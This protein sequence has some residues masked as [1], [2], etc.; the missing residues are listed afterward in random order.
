MSVPTPPRV[1]AML[2]RLVT[3]HDDRESLLA[4]L[5]MGFVER[6]SD[7]ARARRWYW[8]Q[9]VGSIPALL[10]RRVELAL[11][12]GGRATVNRRGA[13]LA[14]SAGDVRHAW[15]LIRRTPIVSVSVVT[16]IALGIASVTAIVSVMEGVF[17]RSLPFPDAQQLVQVGTEIDG[18]GRAPEVNFLDARDFRQRSTTLS[19]I[20]CYA[21]NPTA[22]RLSPGQLS[23]SA[24]ILAAGIDL[25]RVLGLRPEIGRWFDA[26]EQ[27]FGGQGVVLVSH[28]FWRQHL[29]A[30]ADVVGR[31]I[32][33]GGADHTIVGVLPDAA[34]R[35][36][37]GGADLWTPLTFPSE[38][39][40]NQRGS[41]ALGAV[42]RLRPG[43][44]ESAARAD[45]SAISRQLAV[46]HADTNSKRR[47][48]IENL[49]D[50][51]VG[52]IRP[53][54][55]ALAGAI[56]FLLA[57]ACLNIAN[58]LLAH[59]HAR[60]RELG[61]R[62][63]IG[64]SRGRLLRQ[65]SCEHLTLFT[66]AGAVG[67]AGAGP[68][69]RAIVRW[70]PG[71]LPLAADIRI[72]VRV[73]AV[74]ALVTFGAML[75]ALAPQAIRL[76]RSTI[77]AD[78]TGGSRIGLSHG[79]RRVTSAFIVVQV[80]MSTVLLAGGVL[81]LRTFTNL[82][83]VSP[84]FS[85][86]GVV[87]IRVSLPADVQRSGEAMVAFQDRVRDVA[88][89]LPGVERAAHAMFVP[90]TSGSWG[91]AY[92]VPGDTRQGP[93]GPLAHFYMVSPEYLS[94]LQ[95]P[96]VRGRGLAS[97]DSAGGARVLVVSE[98][99]ARQAF[100]RVDVVGEH[101]DWN[102][103]RW[104]L[105]GVARDVRHAS[106][107]QAPDADAYVPRAQV[108]RSPT[109]LVLRTK[110]PGPIVAG[111]IYERLKA[112]APQ[113]ALT[114]AAT[115]SGLLAA[116]LAPER[117]RALLT[118]VIAALSLVLAV[119]GL[120]GVVAYAVSRRSREI[121]VRIALG[122]RRSTVLGQIFRESGRVVA[123]GL[124]PGVGGAV[125]LARWLSSQ[126]V[127]QASIGGAIGATVAIFAAAAFIATFT[128][129]RRASRVDP[130]SVLR[131]E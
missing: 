70:Y 68:L 35:F 101:I 27:A 33:I 73:L 60:T 122:A 129:A 96:L 109:W 13:W 67:V 54:M 53:M 95:V 14:E 71:D 113:L 38:S 6:A 37:T 105:V 28:R 20:A 16:A 57:V 11:R 104:T 88:A 97:S 52:P 78:L 127:V 75:L 12:G 84:G 64:A 112:E 80:A 48:T 46:E 43:V 55:L 102:D 76:R 40:L 77:V 100:G 41:I 34:S 23:M 50:A 111:Q 32:D 87:L 90:F 19:S 44:T 128:P 3:H 117:F 45:L 8:R 62:A 47:A 69:A 85:P 24:T 103:D 131:S 49:Q 4:D 66:L 58:L 56:A 114:D 63:A 39:F 108:P 61:I 81:L 22:V 91:D 7:P 72:D 9:A 59:V 31:H 18:F 15:R 21:V 51:M 106:L 74:A 121:G 83:A 65:L 93:N 120:H 89:S 36:P 17:L 26:S 2:L 92:R 123:L 42:G 86:D 25:D 5:E 94:V 119:V 125:M 115:M 79:H 130:V 1:A 118:G 116:N 29:G 30:D 110:Q 98:A 10:R 107:W 124:V 99:F 126:G 82:T